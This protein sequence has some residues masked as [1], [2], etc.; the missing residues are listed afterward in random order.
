MPE[1]KQLIKK[2]VP[3]KLRRPKS[4]DQRILLGNNSFISG[5]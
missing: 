1:E 4:E 2:G 5:K 3:S